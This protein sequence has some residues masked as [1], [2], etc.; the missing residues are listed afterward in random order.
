MCGPISAP[1]VPPTID[2]KSSYATRPGG[3]F[4]WWV[5]DGR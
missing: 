5:F 1:E 3:H 2:V 4:S